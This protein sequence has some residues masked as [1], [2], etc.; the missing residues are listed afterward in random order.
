MD[1]FGDSIGAPL[2][3]ANDFGA[4]GGRKGSGHWFYIASKTPNRDNLLTGCCKKIYYSLLIMIYM[5]V[6]VVGLTSGTIDLFFF[7]LVR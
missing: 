7:F 6:L 2:E 5:P 4:D 1:L 3:E